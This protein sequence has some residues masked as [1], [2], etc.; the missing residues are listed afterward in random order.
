MTSSPLLHVERNV[1]LLFANHILVL[2]LLFEGVNQRPGKDVP[3]LP[4][5]H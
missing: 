5:A 3:V 1:R 2:F 4:V